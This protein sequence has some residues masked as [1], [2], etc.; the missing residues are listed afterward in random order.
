VRDPA[1]LLLDAVLP[2]CRDDE[3]RHDVRAHRPL[4]LGRL[5]PALA[6]DDLDRPAD[7]EDP[8]LE[9]D[10]RPAQREQLAAVQP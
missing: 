4:C 6:V 7:R 3:G 9:V 8:G 2:Q 10:V 5:L 1:L